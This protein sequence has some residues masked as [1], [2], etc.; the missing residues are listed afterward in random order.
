MK[1]SLAVF[2]LVVFHS[3]ILLI[4]NQRE[5]VRSFL[6]SVADLKPISTHGHDRSVTAGAAEDHCRQQDYIDV[7]A[8]KFESLKARDQNQSF[9]FVMMGN[10][11]FLPFVQNWLCNT[12]LM[13][14]VH[15]RT[16]LLFSDDAYKDIEISHFKVR[17]LSIHS[18]FPREFHA[19]LDYNTYGY[20][21][22]VQLRVRV[23]LNL[24]YAG[25][26]YLLCEPDALWVQNPLLDPELRSD[27]DLVGFD[28]N[29]GV[30]GF[31]W[32]RVLPTPDVLTLFIEMER[33][34]SAQMPRSDRPVQEEL[35]VRGEQDILHALISARSTKPY[36]NLKF[37]MLL[38]TKYTS[39]KW[40]DGGVAIRKACRDAGLPFVINNNWIVGNVAKI[41]RAKR[42]GHWFLQ[43]GHCASWHN[44]TVLQ[45]Q[46]SRMLST[47]T[48]LAP[49]GQI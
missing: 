31:G 45:A 46:L 17:S 12:V 24:T 25:I 41:A 28:D 23:V 38:Q 1:Q 43:D 37:K 32:L 9:L 11:A 35:I 13:Q 18:M 5:L 34:F 36:K 20:W 44:V 30:P 14:G 27:D 49:G 10:R 4:A 3:C 40:Y 42:W 19:N 48:S 7:A 29:N 6:G 15:E 26:P 47:M 16:L 8:C 22:L 39:G 33:I 2:V 21:R